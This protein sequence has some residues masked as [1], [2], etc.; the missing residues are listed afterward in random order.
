MYIRKR[1]QCGL[2]ELKIV[3]RTSKTDRNKAF[4]TSKTFT[5]ME[6]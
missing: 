6:R 4:N 3:G 1:L 5:S 2:T